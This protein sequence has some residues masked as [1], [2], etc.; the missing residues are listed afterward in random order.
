MSEHDPITGN[1]GAYHRPWVEGAIKR[2]Y[3][4]KTGVNAVRPGHYHK[5]ETN[6]RDGKWMIECEKRAKTPRQC[7]NDGCTTQLSRYN[8][9]PICAS[10][11]PDYEKYDQHR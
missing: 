10:C 11:D 2:R 5:P 1:S 6:T 9:D 8:P 4:A 7:A 3:N